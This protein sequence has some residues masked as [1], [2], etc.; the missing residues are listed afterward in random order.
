[1]EYYPWGKKISIGVEKGAIFSALSKRRA[2]LN[3]HFDLCCSEK[4]S[5]A[6]YNRNTQRKRIGN[7]GTAK[8]TVSYCKDFT[9]TV[10]HNR[11]PDRKRGEIPFKKTS[12]YLD[13][14]HYLANTCTQ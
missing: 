13:Y 4:R 12:W 10:T 5:C 3:P 1:M 14:S 11:D 6:A 9:F 7:S 8:K 2:K